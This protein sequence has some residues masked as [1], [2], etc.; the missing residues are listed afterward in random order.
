MESPNSQTKVHLDNKKRA[1]VEKLI[2]DVYDKLDPTHANSDYYR[3]VFSKMD[4]DQ[5]LNF[6]RKRMPLR[7]HTT[8][9]KVEPKMYNI[10][11]AFK[12]IGAPLFEKVNL[13]HIY[14]DANGHA[15]QSK[16][17]LVVYMHIKR[18]KQMLSKKTSNAIS[19]I[20]RDMRTGL[21]LGHSKGGKM[22]DREAETLAVNSMEYT[23]D[24]LSRPRADD[25]ITKE[26][27]YSAIAD[28]GYVARDE[29]DMGGGK[30]LAKNML[31]VYFLGCHI[32][33]NL[34]GQDNGY[35]NDATLNSKKK[36][37]I[38]RK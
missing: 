25:M 34:Q 16:E 27:L 29:I 38:E 24:E 12:I 21:L 32:I 2:Y 4:N 23:M 17:C 28:K 31:Y 20:E 3:E 36:L 1:E 18:M 33:S 6:F 9:F 35:M 8:L 15:V 14:K 5:F 30:S 19:T 11:K 22:S 7:F 37:E 10:I 13:N 26:K